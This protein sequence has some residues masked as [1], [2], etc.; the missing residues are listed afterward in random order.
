MGLDHVTPFAQQYVDTMGRW[1][2]ALRTTEHFLLPSSPPV[3]HHD[4]ST[5]RQGAQPALRNPVRPSWV[6]AEL[7][8][9]EWE[10]DLF[11]V[12]FGKPLNLG[13][14]CNA[15][16]LLFLMFIYLFW[17]RERQRQQEQ[18]RGRERGRERENPKQA[19]CCQCR[20]QCTARIHKPWDHDLSQSQEPD[21]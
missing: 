16:I 1:L 15:A 14:V 21:A 3:T 2:K 18:G 12:V 6:M 11:L 17:E 8:T 7:P 5:P 9:Q 20:T 19:P 13:V 10:I 4:K